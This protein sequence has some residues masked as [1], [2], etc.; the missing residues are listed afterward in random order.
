VRTGRGY[1]VIAGW[2]AQHSHHRLPVKGGI[3]IDAK[4]YTPEE[5]ER[6][7]RR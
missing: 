6:I 7:T 3:R 2:R 5:M 1:E 4:Q